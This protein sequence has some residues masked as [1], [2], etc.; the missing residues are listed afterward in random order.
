MKSKIF[1]NYR[2]DDSPWNSLALYQELIRHFGKDNIFKDFN[3]I[4]PGADFV[5][6]I[7]EALKSCDVLLVLISESWA[8]IKDKNGNLRINNDDDF[9]RIEIATALKQNI[10]VIPVLFDNAVLPHASEL[11]EDL[12]NLSRRQSIEID[13]TRFEAD[14]T[15]LVETIKKILA[16]NQGRENTAVHSQTENIK[17][18]QPFNSTSQ[19]ETTDAPGKT[20]KARRIIVLLVVL[21]GISVLAY[22]LLFRDSHKTAQTGIASSTIADSNA[23]NIDTA[24]GSSIVKAA[25]STT[26]TTGH[27]KKDSASTASVTTGKPEI[28][29]DDDAVP[30]KVKPQNRVYKKF[31]EAYEAVFKDAAFA[32]IHVRGDSFPKRRTELTSYH[33]KVN[34]T[35]PSVEG[36]VVYIKT[37]EWSFNFSIKGPKENETEKFRETENMI[38]H[39]FNRKNMKYEKNISTYEGRT[40]NPL[41]SFRYSALPYQVEFD[42]IIIGD[43]Y[44]H[45]VV[46]IYEPPG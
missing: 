12:K 1:I 20:F 28:K 6:S 30:G 10:K 23:S 5:E 14:T 17:E 27:I 8:N 39:S 34:I 11:P 4:L 43:H 44:Q 45:H 22:F 18:L 26:T 3:T 7:E 29:K 24:N 31:S 19:K 40:P 2:K 42:R 21:A 38:I 46:I 13:K 15:K 9:V 35:D 33:T 16:S 32:F 37:N 25:D 36:K 41:Q